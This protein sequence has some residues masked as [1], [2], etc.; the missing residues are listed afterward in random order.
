MASPDH[1]DEQSDK[2]MKSLL[3]PK[4]VFFPEFFFH[5]SYKHF[6]SGAV[7]F[8]NCDAG[9]IYKIIEQL[10]ADFQH[11]TFLVMPSVER[12][13]LS[14]RDEEY[15]PGSDGILIEIH[16]MSATAFLEPYYLIKAM[17]VHS[18][19]F[20]P[21]QFFKKLRH[22]VQFHPCSG[23]IVADHVIATEYSFQFIH[24]NSQSMCKYVKM[25]VN[26][27]HP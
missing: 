14:G 12:V 21:L 24:G 19:G 7:I 2:G 15:A 18:V 22:P 4:A 16:I 5:R 10:R 6:K 26:M 20:H 25:M 17:Q 27:K 23:G 1:Y 11:V 9:H 8:L 3:V 13:N